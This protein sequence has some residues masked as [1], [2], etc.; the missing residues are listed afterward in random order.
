ALLRG[1][2]DGIVMKA[3]DRDR[4]RRYAT[5]VALASDLE[6]YLENRP[7]TARPASLGYRARKYARRHVAGI[8]VV[9]GAVALLLTFAMTQAVQLRRVIRE[10]DRA[11]RISAFMI[12]MFAVSNSSEARGNV[13]T[14]REI[15]DRSAK[16]IEASFTTDPELQAKMMY[17]MAL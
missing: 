9:A 1:D 10:R 2:L 5:L 12:S 17:T 6:N 13:V 11:D 16:D 7:I 14:A 15:L 4:E 3:L 8:M